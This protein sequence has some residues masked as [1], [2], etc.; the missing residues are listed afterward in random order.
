MDQK[1]H[2]WFIPLLSSNFPWVALVLAL[3]VLLSG[4][5]VNDS[6]AP[7]IAIVHSLFQASSL[8][9]KPQFKTSSLGLQAYH[10]P[11]APLHT[12]ITAL[13]PSDLTNPFSK[14]KYLGACDWDRMHYLAN[15]SGFYAPSLTNP[16]ILTS[17]MVNITCTRQLSGYRFSPYEVIQSVLLP[18]VKGV[19]DEVSMAK[20]ETSNWISLWYAGIQNLS[21]V[22]IGLSMT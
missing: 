5:T 8:E 10:D 6:N 22:L 17:E 7:A 3:T 21:V 16:P 1:S 12:N 19:V 2:L 18:S 14:S 20:Y 11:F 9:L 15:C 13:V 4:I